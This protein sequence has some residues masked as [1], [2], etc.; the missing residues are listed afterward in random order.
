MDI[1]P[2]QNTKLLKQNLEKLRKKLLNLSARNRL[3]NFKHT[4]SSSLRIID[5]VPNQ[6]FEKKQLRGQ[7]LIKGS[8]LEL[9]LDVISPLLYNHA[10]WQD[11]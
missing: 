4:K 3:L 11:R 7:V 2:A 1:G 6:L 10:L 9:I 5:E 8:S